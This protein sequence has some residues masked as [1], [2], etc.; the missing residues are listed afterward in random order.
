MMD[1]GLQHTIVFLPRQQGGQEPP[2]STNHLANIRALADMKV[3]AIV[4]TTSVGDALVPHPRFC[5]A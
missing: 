2:H 1:R 4:A 5:L 3:D